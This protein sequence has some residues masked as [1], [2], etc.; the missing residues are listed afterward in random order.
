MRRVIV[1]AVLAAVLVPAQVGAQSNT[2]LAPGVTY[3]RDVKSIGGRRV[4]SHVITA[5][6]PG[7]LYDVRPVLSNNMLIGR[8]TVSSMQRR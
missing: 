5:P 8:E 1:F 4:V 2:E 7:G 6:A 3:T